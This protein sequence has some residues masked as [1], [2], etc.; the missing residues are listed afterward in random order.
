MRI[1]S[2]RVVRPRHCGPIGSRHFNALVPFFSMKRA[3]V[4]FEMNVITLDLDEGNVGR[5]AWF[6]GWTVNGKRL[7]QVFTVGGDYPVFKDQSFR[8]HRERGSGVDK[9]RFK[10]PDDLKMGLARHSRGVDWDGCR[11]RGGNAD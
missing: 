5:V 1:V 3:S 10:I 9:L 8:S 7:L 2:G 11:F 4:D 6:N